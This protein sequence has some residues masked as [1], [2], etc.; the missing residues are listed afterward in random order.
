MLRR[1][2]A[3]AIAGQ[4]Q[5]AARVSQG[6]SSAFDLS[7]DHAP[8]DALD[9]SISPTGKD[10]ELFRTIISVIISE[11]ISASDGRTKE[12]ASNQAPDVA[13]KGRQGAWL[14]RDAELT[15]EECEAKKTELLV[16]K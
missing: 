5:R 15:E 4:R 9:S 12:S 8:L 16:R 6:R 7:T 10:R 2:L 3:T 14:V 11:I 13:G 1:R